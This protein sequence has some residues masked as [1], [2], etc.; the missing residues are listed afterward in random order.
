MI[1]DIVFVQSKSLAGRLVRFFSGSRWNHVFIRIAPIP[2]GG[3]VILEANGLKVRVAVERDEERAVFRLK[4]AEEADILLAAS[5]ALGY[6]GKS[7][8]FA[9]VLG[10]LAVYAARLFDKTIKNPIRGGV[11]CT[12]LVILYL[13]AV[14]IGKLF[15]G[16]DKDTFDPVL[17]YD[18]LRLSPEFIQP[19][20]IRI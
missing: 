19:S 1:G 5:Y 15:A 4:N 20:E 2:G 3:W 6:V 10:F 16:S 11:I 12:E 7:Y 18:M 9:Q 13:G 17:L 8:G 14:G